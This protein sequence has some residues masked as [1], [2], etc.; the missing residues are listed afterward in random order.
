MTRVLAQ[1]T[2]TLHPFIHANTFNDLWCRSGGNTILI[3]QFSIKIASRTFRYLFI[4]I[5]EFCP[6]AF[7]WMTKKND[8][9]KFIHGAI[10]M[11]EITLLGL[12]RSEQ[13]KVCSEAWM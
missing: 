4:V 5:W 3:E 12:H 1:A 9:D 10:V 2:Q 8:E 13:S 6:S 11:K 7:C